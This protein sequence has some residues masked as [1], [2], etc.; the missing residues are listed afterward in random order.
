MGATAVRIFERNQILSDQLMQR[1]II[2]EANKL[3]RKFAPLT[4]ALIK[5]TC[6]RRTVLIFYRDRNIWR[7]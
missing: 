1:E 3:R 2:E 5:E 4:S 6:L 7:R